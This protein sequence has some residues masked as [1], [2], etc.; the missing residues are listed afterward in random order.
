LVRDFFF[1]FQKPPKPLKKN[2]RPIELGGG[3]GFSGADLAGAPPTKGACF[4][5]NFFP[6][7]NPRGFFLAIFF[8]SLAREGEKFSAKI[9]IP[10]KKRNPKGGQK[11]GKRN[12]F[13]CV[14]FWFFFSLGALFFFWQGD[15][16][17]GGAVLPQTP[18]ISGRGGG[19]FLGPPKTFFPTPGAYLAG[20]PGQKDLN[21][22]G[23][24]FGTPVFFADFGGEKQ[25]PKKKS[26][27]S[28]WGG[29]AGWERWFGGEK[30]GGGGGGGQFFF[31]LGGAGF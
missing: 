10:K 27:I 5:E 17:G 4:F 8:F 30:P 11:N 9:F 7:S 12:L 28:F 21:F 23:G 31:S 1:F 20:G 13:F 16:G 29:G 6:G 15:L 2:P 19:A 22:T 26:G 3:P 14:L 24:Q 25:Q 18:F